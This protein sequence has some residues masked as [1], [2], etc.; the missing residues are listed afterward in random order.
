MPP[1]V[2]ACTASELEQLRE[3]FGDELDSVW[4][5]AEW[6]RHLHVPLG[7]L[8]SLYD[9]VNQD[10]WQND[11]DD[12]VDLLL[13]EIAIDLMRDPRVPV[14]DGFVAYATDLDRYSGSEDAARH[15]AK[16]RIS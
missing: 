2:A 3:S 15:A 6:K 11:L 5:P 14:A 8:E 12:E 10:I 16:G 4:N 9:S 1:H 13:S 7:E